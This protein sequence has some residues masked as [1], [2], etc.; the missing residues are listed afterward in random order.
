[1]HKWELQALAFVREIVLQF[2]M[3][4]GA[5]ETRVALVAFHDS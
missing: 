5:A 3:G 4:S 2:V 1:M